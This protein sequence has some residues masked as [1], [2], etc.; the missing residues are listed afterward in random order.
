MIQV[1]TG[2]MIWL[3]LHLLQTQKRLSC[4]TVESMKKIT[5]GLIQRIQVLHCKS[6]KYGAT[7]YHKHVS[8]SAYK[9]LLASGVLEGGKYMYT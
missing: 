2:S 9:I 3:V 6:I 4:T 8:M 5:F 1:K 7:K